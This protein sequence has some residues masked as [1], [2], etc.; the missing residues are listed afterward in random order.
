MQFLHFTAWNTNTLK[1][2]TEYSTA[3][4]VSNYWQQKIQGNFL[5]NCDQALL[6]I[7]DVNVYGLDLKLV[8]RNWKYS[9]ELLKEYIFE[10]VRAVHFPSLPSRKKCMF[11]FDK[12]IDYEDYADKINFSLDKYALIEIEPIENKSKSIR[13]KLSLLD[14]NGLPYDVI[15]EKA[16]EYW[17]GTEEINTDTEILLE[18][19]F[20]ITDIIR[21]NQ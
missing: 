3:C 18:G 8:L 14:C 11:L 15:F 20:I 21:R 17:K 2:N 6:N 10:E 13:A 1:I 5:A 7:P 19:N 12:S 9:I 4:D 16:K